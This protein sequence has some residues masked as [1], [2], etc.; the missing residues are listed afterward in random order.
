MVL[1]VCLFLK[2]IYLFIYFEKDPVRD[3]GG[4]ERE[5]ERENSKQF[6]HRTWHGARNCEALRSWPEAK[7]RVGH[8][9]DLS[10]PGAPKWHWLQ[11]RFC[12]EQR[13]RN[14]LFIFKELLESIRD[15]VRTCDLSSEAPKD[16]DNC[17]IR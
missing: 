7:P 8:L 9:T 14:L 5:V 10:H 6:P 16:C 11:Y 2:F 13:S 3:G 17:Y 15:G 1:F 4:V 12:I